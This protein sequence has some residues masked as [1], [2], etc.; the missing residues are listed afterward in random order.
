MN[1]IKGTLRHHNLR[2][3]GMTSQSLPLS[4]IIDDRAEGSL[5]PRENQEQNRATQ[6]LTPVM[7]ASATGSGH[8]PAAETGIIAAISVEAE[9]TDDS[10][11]QDAS[12]TTAE[13]RMVP[14]P[15]NEGQ[16]PRLPTA[17][18]VE[19][20][21][22]IAEI[23]KIMLERMHLS[24]SHESRGNKAL[25]RIEELDP[26][27]IL[28]DIGLPDM[29]GWAVLDAIKA[30]RGTR[31]PIVI[32][33]TAY[34]DAANRLAGKLQGVDHYLVKPFTSDEVEQVILQALGGSVG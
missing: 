7:L 9:G 8:S 6:T 34:S 29:T 1:E 15:A 5:E 3:F 10:D 31:M 30:R 12:R 23:L 22:E 27:V 17:L 33:I 14:N 28:L 13:T 32:V 18:I 21:P 4:I 24:V 16:N 11:R 20:A 19:D 26:D 2:G 25:A